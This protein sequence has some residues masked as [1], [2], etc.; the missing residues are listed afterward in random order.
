MITNEEIKKGLRELR[1]IRPDAAFKKGLRAVVLNHQ[2]EKTAS[3]RLPLPFLKIG[4]VLAV[5]ALVIT[6]LTIE[7]SPTPALSS[8][9]NAG[10]LEKEFD[11]LTINVQIEDARYS[12][13]ANQTIASALN[14][15]E[16]TNVKHLNNSLITKEEAD[17]LEIESATNP[18]IDTLLDTVIF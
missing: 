7:L 14:E 11:S 1:A 13:R 9:F 3:F 8:S 2:P 4:G 10:S 17:I 18:E 16:N 6:A 12:E 15:I 5:I